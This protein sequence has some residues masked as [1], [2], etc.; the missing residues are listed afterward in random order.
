MLGRVHAPFVVMGRADASLAVCISVGLLIALTSHSL[1]SQ[2]IRHT[3]V[4]HAQYLT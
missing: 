1:A 3:C 2:L 4:L